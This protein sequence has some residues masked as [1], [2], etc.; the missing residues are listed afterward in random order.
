MKLGHETETRS[1]RGYPRDQGGS[2][3]SGRRTAADLMLV[4][5]AAIWGSAFSAQ[6]VAAAHVGHFTYN[7]LRFL[8]AVGVVALVLRGQWRSVER[9]EWRGGVLAGLILAAASALQ[10]A[11]IA[12]TTAGKAGFITG[13]YV[14][15]VPLFV[16]LIWRQRPRR[17]AW[18]A[19]LLAAA[20]LYLLSVEGV[21]TLQ[22]GDA[23]ELGGAVLWALHVIVVGQLVRHVDPLRLSLVQYLVCGVANTLLGVLLE[24]HTWPGL[25]AAWW[26]VLYGGAI[27]VGLG[28]TLQAYGQR[29]APATDAAVILSMEAVFAA[30]FGW[31][32]LRERLTPVQ[33]GGCAL[34]LTGMLV[35]HASSRARPDEARSVTLQGSAGHDEGR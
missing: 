9:G 12:F 15:L 33:V 16:A 1:G 35:A 29:D 27:S 10:Q 13:L 24:R 31:L 3:E 2:T 8:L 22:L 14:V 17:L 21:W 23:L 19:S 5:V 28:Y 20:G 4:S 25:Q 30:L 11:G 34:M 26:T 6:R 32:L 18:G 7:G